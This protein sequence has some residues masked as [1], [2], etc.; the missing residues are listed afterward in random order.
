MLAVNDAPLPGDTQSG[1]VGA[2]NVYVSNIGFSGQTGPDRFFASAVTLSFGA[3]GWTTVR[4][5]LTINGGN[6]HSLNCSGLQ[7]CVASTSADVDCRQGNATGLVQTVHSVRYLAQSIPVPVS[8][9]RATC[10]DRGTPPQGPFWAALDPNANQSPSG[11]TGGAVI[12]SGATGSY[13]PS[14][15]TPGMSTVELCSYY[16]TYVSGDGGATWAY[17]STTWTGCQ[18]I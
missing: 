18:F 12:V 5:T 13:M 11:G 7:K 4:G 3:V 9:T 17:L 14:G 2:S 6:T 1:Q 16:V 10:T 8:D 15:G